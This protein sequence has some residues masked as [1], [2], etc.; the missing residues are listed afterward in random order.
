MQASISRRRLLSATAS[1]LALTFFPVPVLAQG[2]GAAEAFGAAMAVV[3]AINDAQDA[4]ALRKAL[5]RINQKLDILI[6]GQQQILEEIAELRLFFS[7][8]MFR[9]FRREKV[10]AINALKDRYDF[11]V[12]DGK[13]RNRTEAQQLGVDLQQATNELGQYDF[14]GFLT[15]SFG[16]SMTLIVYRLL[17]TKPG[18]L[19]RLKSGFAAKLSVW[20]SGDNPFGVT[21]A[22]MLARNETVAAQ[23]RLDAFPRK[24]Q[25]S[26]ETGRNGNQVCE[27][28]RYVMLTGDLTNPFTGMPA[29]EFHS[30]RE[31]E[32]DSDRRPGCVRC[33]AGQVID[34]TALTAEQTIEP[35]YSGIPATGRESGGVFPQVDE[36]NRVRNVVIA[37]LRH[38]RDL[39][40]IK[41]LMESLKARLA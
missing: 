20:L 29:T 1:G 38:E 35:D 19:A 26:S 36:A 5:Q 9:Q 11:T 8:E 32:R 3:G 6:S 22:M 30:C 7:E 13:L 23:A 27:I 4:K 21:K 28:R 17:G 10:F 24:I 37:A 33:L 18:D 41:G 2:I 31:W 16:V 12:R 25:L 40:W 34:K 14:G 15:F 39:V